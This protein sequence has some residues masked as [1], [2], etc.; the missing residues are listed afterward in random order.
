[1]G[2]QFQ[3][4][5]FLF[6]DTKCKSDRFSAAHHSLMTPTLEDSTASHDLKLFSV[7]QTLPF[8]D[9][10]KVHLIPSHVILLNLT[11]CRHRVFF[12]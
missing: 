2:S 9:H 5:F 8:L 6:D 3:K 12:H 1:M 7:I 4:H 11:L 10:V